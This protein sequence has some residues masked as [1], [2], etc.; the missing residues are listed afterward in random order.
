[1]L[2]E[3][4]FGKLI[5][6]VG[7]QSITAFFIIS[8]N[9]CLLLATNCFSALTVRLNSLVTL[10]PFLLIVAVKTTLASGLPT[11]GLLTFP[12]LSIIA[13]LLDFHIILA[14]SKEVSKL[15]SFSILFMLSIFKESL[16]NFKVSSV[17]TSLALT[18]ILNSLFFLQ[19]LSL[20]QL[21]KLYFHPYLLF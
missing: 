14:P 8:S 20:I 10:F 17:L 11:I 18:I 13:S 3:L 21:L 2:L 19:F 12:V 5:F 15:I 1:M 9:S 4:K 16:I 6:I 7:S